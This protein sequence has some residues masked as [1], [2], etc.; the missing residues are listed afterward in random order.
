MFTYSS[1]LFS[2]IQ[3]DPLMQDLINKYS[4]FVLEPVEKKSLINKVS[5]STGKFCGRTKNFFSKTETKA[6]TL[7]AYWAADSLIALFLIVAGAST[8]AIALAA[9]MLILHT[10]ATFSVVA[11]IMK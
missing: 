11:E 3:N 8:L 4:S 10:Y 1:D 7:L 6:A 2:Q 5:Y 9:F